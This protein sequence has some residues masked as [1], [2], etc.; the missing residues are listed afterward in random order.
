M[1]VH[2]KLHPYQSRFIPNIL[3]FRYPGPYIILRRI[4]LTIWDCQ[5]LP[6]KYYGMHHIPRE[7]QKFK[8]D[9]LSY[10]YSVIVTQQRVDVDNKKNYGFVDPPSNHPLSEVLG[11]VSNVLNF[12]KSWQDRPITNNTYSFYNRM[13]LYRLPPSTPIMV[14]L[15]LL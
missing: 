4:S 7:P 5:R 6:S 11:G 10:L 13:D 9:R 2:Q 1:W 12:D 14:A 8:E 3:M 15:C